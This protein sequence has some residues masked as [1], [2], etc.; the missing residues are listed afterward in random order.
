MRHAYLVYV[1][2]IDVDYGAIVD[3]NRGQEESAIPLA[4]AHA[5]GFLFLSQSFLIRN[6]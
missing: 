4:P 2:Y 3:L 6:S 5:P 1:Q